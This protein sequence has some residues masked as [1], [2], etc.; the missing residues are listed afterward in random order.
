MKLTFPIGYAVGTFSI[1]QHRSRSGLRVS[2]LHQTT[3]YPFLWK[4]N[5]NNLIRDPIG[6][7]AKLG[8]KL[9]ES[10]GISPSFYCLIGS[11]LHFPL[12]SS[13]PPYPPCYR[14]VSKSTLIG[15]ELL[16]L[17]PILYTHS[18]DSPLL[19]QNCSIKKNEIWQFYLKSRL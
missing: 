19:L 14:L 9:V 16:N 1:F 2:P 12:S 11:S 7:S 13:H 15:W 3:R 10:S 4:R 17:F 18:L 5:K 6:L 8:G